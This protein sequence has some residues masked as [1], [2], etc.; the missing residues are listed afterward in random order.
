[1]GGDVDDLLRFVVPDIKRDDWACK[2]LI[3]AADLFGFGSGFAMEP[4]KLTTE[5]QLEDAG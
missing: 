5:L 3:K 4:L 1:M 2:P